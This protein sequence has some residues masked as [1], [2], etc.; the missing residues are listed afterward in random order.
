MTFQDVIEQIKT[1]TTFSEEEFS[2]AFE[3]S[4]IYKTHELCKESLG[5]EVTINAQGLCAKLVTRQRIR[6][7]N[8]KNPFTSIEKYLEIPLFFRPVYTS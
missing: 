3:Q 7:F 4:R 5:D 2:Y 1:A 6:Q 8:R